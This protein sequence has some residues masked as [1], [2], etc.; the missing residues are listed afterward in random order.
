MI[1]WF[2]KTPPFYGFYLPFGL[3]GVFRL[4][5][6]RSKNESS[7]RGCCWPGLST[8][9]FGV[10][11]PQK[12][13]NHLPT[14][15]LIRKWCEF[16]GGVHIT[17]Q[18]KTGS[19]CGDYMAKKGGISRLSFWF[20][21]MQMGVSNLLCRFLFFWRSHGT[22]GSSHGSFSLP[23]G[24]TRCPHQKEG[25]L[26]MHSK[27]LQEFSLVGGFDLSAILSSSRIQ[28]VFSSIYPSCLFSSHVSNGG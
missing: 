17:F 22:C 23:I 6:R 12:E 20:L 18:K 4:V 21:G 5:P 26:W 19:W 11:R 1:T 13:M 27:T 16:C 8:L 10:S 3:P 9:K 14:I 24:C 15:N 7:C 28:M 25:S 2:A